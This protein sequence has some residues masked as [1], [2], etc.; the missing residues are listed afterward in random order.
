MVAEEG[1]V[2]VPDMDNLYYGPAG[3][4]VDARTTL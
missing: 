4:A 1:A 2:A 3:T